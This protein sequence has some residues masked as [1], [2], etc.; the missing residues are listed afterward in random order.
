MLRL[1]TSH[2]LEALVEQL[3]EVAR[4]PLRSPLRPEMVVVQSQGMARWLKLELAARHGICANYQFPFPKAFCADVLAANPGERVL[5]DREVMLWDIMRLLPEMLK[6]PEFKALKHY[7]ADRTD[8]RK[9][10]QLAS[11]IAN[12]FDQYLVFRPELVLA[13]DQGRLSGTDSAPNPDELWQA[14][15][16]R[17]LQQERPVAHLAALLGKFKEQVARAEFEAR[18]VPERVCIFGISALPPSYLHVFCELGA[19]VDLH[20]FLLQPSREYWGLIVNARESERM[21]KAARQDAAGALHLEAGNRLL[22]SLGTLG[23][24]FLNLVLDA[25]DWDEQTLFSDPPEENLLQNIQADIFHLRDR[26]R[27]DCPRLAISETDASLR[28]HACHSPLREVEVL[29]DHLLDWFE[30]DRT[31]RPRDV[32]VMT[33][34]IETYAPFIQAVF[35][36]PGEKNPG[37]PFSVADRGLRSSSQVAQAFLGLLSLPMTRLETSRVLRILEA[38]PVRARF[39]LSEPDLDIVRDWVCRTNIRWGQ[40]ARQRESLGL[41]G[42]PENTWQQ[43]M[44]RLFAG[45]AMAG[46]GE[47][48]FGEVLPFDGVEGG[49]AEVLGH[50]AEYLKRLFDLVAQLKERR[51]IGQWEEVLLA[52]LET[53]FQPEDASLPDVLFIRSTLRQLAKQAAE[54]GHVEPV[55]LAVMLESL[56]QK[57]GEDQFGSGFITGGVTFCALKPMRSIPFKVICLI[58]MNDG[59]FP[60]AD[61]RLSFDLMAQKPRP[62]D[63]SLRDDDR[64]LFLETLLSARRRLHI[65]YVGQSIRDNSEVPPSVLVSELL[66]YVAQAYEVPGR[67]ILKDHVLVRHRLQAFSPAYFT[68]QDKRLF[69]YSM[70]NRQAGQRGQ[71][72]RVVPPSFLDTPLSEPGVEWREVE[73]SAL[74]GFFCNPAKWLLT[75]R[76]GMRLE[77]KEEALEEVEPF[78]VGSLENYS[79]RQELVERALKGEATREALRLM[80]AAGRL[81]LGEAGALNFNGLQA[82]AEEFLERLR[83][84]LGEGYRAPV[85]VDCRLGEFHLT[86][87][88][89]RVTA[90]GLLHY[91]CAGLKAKDRLRLW[92]EHLVLNAAATGG[93]GSGAV[94]VGSD[95]TL[96][97]SPPANAPEVLLELLRLYWRGLRQPLKF[98]PQTALAYAEAASKRDPLAVARRS[99]EGNDF[100][101][102]P[103]ESDD[104]Y[105]DLCFHNV[106]PLDEEFEETALVVFG[107]L[108]GGLKEA[109][110]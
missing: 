80:K 82:A 101:T 68:G 107:P 56:N 44:D 91:R 86:G 83:P 63:R 69:S 90:S 109:K 37:I 15:L 105:F 76:L 13:W 12:L 58:G 99:W 22:A 29:Y 94:L 3:A 65:S 27:D 89:R 40:D 9:R 32:L 36:W 39:G 87:E 52:A 104:P 88:I 31:L 108:L 77:G 93:A 30:H 95:D 4:T 74:A 33:P 84:H 50:L 24:D 11:Q 81:P 98:F 48:M 72:A 67:D 51:T 18:A 10:F 1:Y 71:A 60:R 92:V 14:A 17:R 70:E 78:E 102:A 26:G 5:L 79:I 64:Y 25:A 53:F 19:R 42:L 41:P 2:R 38:G 43:G 55:D 47:Q 75:R 96:T 20:L 106:D 54:A 110:S 62:G 8:T 100:S 103:P 97:A 16:W 23:R 21:R 85:P 46:K 61:R 66:D 35:D 59:D 34:D 57:L 73:V 7:L 45:Y 49:R 28:V 6:R